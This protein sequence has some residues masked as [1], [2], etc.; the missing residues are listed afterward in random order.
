MEPSWQPS[1][2]QGKECILAKIEKSVV[3]MAMLSTYL[4]YKLINKDLRQSLDR[5]A[6]QTTV[7]RETKY[8]KEN[9]GKI[10]SAKEFLADHRLYKYAMEAYGLDDMIYA[11]A[12]MR[13]VLESDLNDENSFVNRL[14]DE[15]YRDFAKAFQFTADGTTA[16]KPDIQ[17]DKQEDDL[18]DTYNQ[19]IANKAKAVEDDTDYYSK[20]VAKLTNIDGFV[21]DRRLVEYSLKA[22]GIDPTYYSAQI[23]RKILTSDP[24]DP[25]SYINSIKDPAYAE[26]A[27]SLQALADSFNFNSDGSLPAGTPVQTTAQIKS[28]TETYVLSVPDRVTPMAAQL[29]TDYFE[30]KASQI[31]SVTQLMGD[32]RLLSYVLTTFGLEDNATTRAN[33]PKALTSDLSNPASFANTSNNDTY[34]KLAQLFNFLPDGKV[35]TGQKMLGRDEL[36]EV[37]VTYMA[38]YDDADQKD[39]SEKIAFYKNMIDVVED[40]D[41][42]VNNFILYDFVMEAF[43]LDPDTESKTTIRK[44]LTSDLSDPNSFANQTRDSRYINLAEAFNFDASGKPRIPRTAQSEGEISSTASAYLVGATGRGQTLDQAKTET[45]YYREQIDRVTSLKDLLDNK[46]LLTYVLEAFGVTLPSTPADFMEQVMKSDVDDPDSFA[47]KLEDRRFAQIAASFNFDTDGN[48]V[49]R[50]EDQSQ[51][52]RGVM[53]TIELHTRQTLEKQS[54]E[55]NEGLRLALYFQRKASGITSVYS[56]LAD[57]A[58]QQVVF[59]ALGLPDEMAQAPVDHQAELLK[60]RLNL[61]DFKDTE[62]LERFLSR[63]SIRYDMENDTSTSLATALFQ[64]AGQNEVSVNAMVS[65]AQLRASRYYS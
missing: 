51:S 34:R 25:S 44:V 10:G 58:L 32:E 35:P 24:S 63:F 29:N 23:M 6:D 28:L 1:F 47:N 16:A 21:N 22:F 18:L 27:E 46:R 55:E 42:L 54:G 48:L 38:A 31:T 13:K 52:R 33:L 49:V 9:I 43:G 61:D 41:G 11:K 45:V 59:K 7:L 17:T 60:S 36:A 5:V 40:V 50:P 12:F 8:Y 4:N 37:T 39:D 30:S 65:F 62:K 64:N 3:G 14:S 26:I 15:R 53:N 56:I 57:R 20:T 2:R 19:E